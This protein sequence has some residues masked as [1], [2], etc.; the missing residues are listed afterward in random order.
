MLLEECSVRDE[1]RNENSIFQSEVAGDVTRDSFD[2]RIRIILL[3]RDEQ[4]EILLLVRI[5]SR[6]R[7]EEG[8]GEELWINLLRQPADKFLGK[9]EVG[10]GDREDVAHNVH[11]ITFD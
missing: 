8:D 9:G 10:G 7:A 3:Q 4:I 1:H 11:L 6:A 5:A 2:V